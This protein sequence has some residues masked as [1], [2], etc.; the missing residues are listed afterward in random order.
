M[1]AVASAAIAVSVGDFSAYIVR[2]LPLRIDRSTEFLFSTDSIALRVVTTRDG[3]LPDTTAI[4]AF[5]C[6][7]T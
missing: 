5:R 4:R 7:N 3:D 6:A 1:A 2:D